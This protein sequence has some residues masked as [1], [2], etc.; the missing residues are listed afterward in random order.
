VKIYQ[1]DPQWSVQKINIIEPTMESLSAKDQQEFGEHEE[2]L[3]KEAHAK[4]LTN[5]KVD[6]NHKVVRQ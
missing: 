4:F 1:I 3:I 2:H 5:F 6:R